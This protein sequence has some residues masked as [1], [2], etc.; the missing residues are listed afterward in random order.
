MIMFVRR[1]ILFIFFLLF[2]ILNGYG[3]GWLKQQSNTDSH[4]RSVYFVNSKIGFAVG[5]NGIILKTTDGGNQWVAKPS[6]TSQYLVSVCFVD[7]LTGFTISSDELYKTNDGGDNWFFQERMNI[8][9][10]IHFVGQDTGFVMG[11]RGKMLVTTDKGITWV[12]QNC[13]ETDIQCF[14]ATNS[15]NMYNGSQYFYIWGSAD[16]GLNWFVSHGD[17]GPG[18]IFDIFFTNQNTGHAVGWGNSQGLSYGMIFKTT[19]AGLD[20][21]KNYDYQ[22]DGLL[23]SVF[24]TNEDIG[25]IVG[26]QGYIIKTTDGGEN[27]VGLDSGDNNALYSVFFCDSLTGYAVGANG[28]ILRTTTGGID[29]SLINENSSS[30]NFYPNPVTNVLNIDLKNFLS[31]KS[32]ILIYNITG[33]LLLKHEVKDNKTRLELSDLQSGLYLVKI[34]N[35]EKAL[36]FKFVKQ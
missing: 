22:D 28:T 24:F 4:L 16:G 31:Q 25:Y 35:S 21:A 20:W 26:Y 5:Q 1:Y 2:S 9:K 30:L 14:W 3:Q 29:L 33:S 10:E 12:K 11:S 8:L 32:D 36:S 6:V 13:I 34:I 18:W 7:S 15:K 23:N 27:W 19:N 17:A